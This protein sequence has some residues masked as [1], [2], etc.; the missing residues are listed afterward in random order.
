MPDNPPQV[1]KGTKRL[2]PF[3]RALVEVGFIV[4]LYYSNLLMGEFEG[5]GLGKRNGMLWAMK[6]I[7]TETNFAIAITT[8]FVGYLVFEYFR[9]RI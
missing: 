6:D 3:W 8:A 2:T 7:L 4:F 1:W 5:S 9:K